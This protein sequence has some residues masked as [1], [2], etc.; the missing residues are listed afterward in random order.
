MDMFA[1]ILY[2]N[3][4]NLIKRKRGMMANG[5]SLTNSKSTFISHPVVENQ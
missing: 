2:R 1:R 5:L 3:L 4:R